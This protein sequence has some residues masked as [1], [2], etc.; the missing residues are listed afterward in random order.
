VQATLENYPLLVLSRDYIL[1][2]H[3]TVKRF[4]RA[5]RVQRERSTCHEQVRGS[6]NFASKL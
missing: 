3:L 5:L 2:K 6:Y 1:V 4:Q